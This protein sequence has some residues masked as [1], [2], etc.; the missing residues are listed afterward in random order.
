MRSI[1]YDIDPGGDIELI[2]KSPNKQDIVPEDTFYPFPSQQSNPSEFL[3]PPCLGRYEVFGELSP[4]D[5]GETPE[6]EVRMRVSSRHLIIASHTFRAML[7][8][9]WIEAALSP[10]PIRQISTE[11]WDAL[12]L[13]IVLDCIHGRHFEI[14]TK[15][16][17]GLLTRI[18]TIVDYYQCREAVQVHYHTWTE[19][20]VCRLPDE[21]DDEEIKVMWL[22]VS[23]V[24][25]DEI[26]FR[27]MA[28]M[29]LRYSKGMSQFETNDLPVSGILGKLDNIRQTLLQKL[30]E[31][32]DSLQ[33]KLMVEEGCDEENNSNCNAV[34]LGI[35]I[36]ERYHI[37]NEFGP[38]V[39]PFHKCTLDK[40]LG[41]IECVDRP[42]PQHHKD[43]KKYEGKFAP[44]T[45]QGILRPV[46]EEI[47]K[48]TKVICLAD[49]QS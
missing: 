2:L 8:G 25:H 38:L 9:P 42:T 24:F 28:D 1:F 39:A 14:P 21:E 20:S 15:I 48:A 23:W 35:L 19:D 17:P 34:L 7:E 45:I 41:Y 43:F 29:F 47:D 22:F 5:E 46:L 31:A 36:R 32:L 11:D 27:K 16:S 30:S 13:A 10:Q 40:I 4:G 12:A 37:A 18:S 33:T 44:C 26:R 49:F 6:A 3:N